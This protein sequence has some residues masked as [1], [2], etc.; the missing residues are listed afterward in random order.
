MTFYEKLARKTQGVSFGL[1][2][3][4]VRV[5]GKDGAKHEVLRIQET[6]VTAPV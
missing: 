5:T 6:H 4:L 2:N 3:F 1:I